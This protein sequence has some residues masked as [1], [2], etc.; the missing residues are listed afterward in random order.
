M[1]INQFLIEASLLP[2]PK[3]IKWTDHANRKILSL[4]ILHLLSL[5]VNNYI[6]GNRN[7]VETLKIHGPGIFTQPTDR[8][9][10]G[11]ILLEIFE[12]FNVFVYMHLPEEK[13]QIFKKI[14]DAELMRITASEHSY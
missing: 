9:Q 13:F 14:H 7:V 2:L 10:R 5:L 3:K 11:E 4:W 1:S 8:K 12:N 6:F